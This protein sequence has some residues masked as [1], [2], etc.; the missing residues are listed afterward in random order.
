MMKKRVALVLALCLLLL[1]LSG[2]ARGE[3][4]EKLTVVCTVFPLYEWT[5]AVVGES[6]NVDVI[7]LVQNGT[8]LHSYQPSAADIVRLRSCDLLVRL[9]GGAD[10][11]IEDAMK[12]APT[13]GRSELRLLELD[14]VC[15]REIAA[16]SVAQEHEHEHAHGHD[17]EH[18][19]SC[20]VDEHFW[21][22]LSNARAAVGA[23]AHALT[24]LDGDHTDRYEENAMKYQAELTELD[25]R[26]REMI[27]QAEEPYAV[28]ADRFPFVYLTEEYDIGYLAAFAGCG[29]DG[30]A[31]VDTVIRLARALDE[32]GLDFVL[33]TESSDKALAE[34]VIR[35]SA[36]RD[37]RIIVLDS[38]QS[39]TEE[40]LEAGKTYLGAMESNLCVLREALLP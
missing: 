24:E 10:G 11:W 5:R 30:D 29:T 7:L 26:Y 12:Q 14:S 40:E 9:G 31:T 18:D 17:H 37:R 16:E 34:G 23:I 33:V 20:G 4:Q 3:K 8:D 6:E 21:L 28:F 15:L 27:G 22:S 39:V 38:L 19:E 13:D 32:R 25:G 36:D 35:A 1:P 2:C